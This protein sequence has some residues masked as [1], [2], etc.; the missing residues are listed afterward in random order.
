ME[1]GQPRSFK[2]EKEF[3]KSF[4]DYVNY[5]KENKRFANIAGFCVFCDVT[6]ETFYKQQE[7]YSDTYK[8][9]QDSLEDH[10]LN[11]HL[12]PAEKIFYM[13]NKFGYSDKVETVNTNLN[14]EISLTPEERTKRIEE[15]KAKL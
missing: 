11:C 15:L 12:S 14:T 9:I 10:T 8:K 1:R 3:Q 4:E 5:C 13:K 6:R 7:Y 2:T